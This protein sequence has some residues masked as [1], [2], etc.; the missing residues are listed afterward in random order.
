[1]IRRLKLLCVTLGLGLCLVPAL[2]P[3]PGYAYNPLADPC[4]SAAA[5][6]SP[7][8]QTTGT[9]P[10]SGKNGIL[11]KVARILSLVAAIGAVI[12]LILG[13]FSYITAAGDASKAAGARK[14]IYAALIGLLVIALAQAF[15]ALV[16]NLVT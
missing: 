5:K 11:Y 10:I 6:K 9:D 2:V 16:L 4:S 15:I 14:T 12:A 7:A 13:G 3:Q 8:C 1:M